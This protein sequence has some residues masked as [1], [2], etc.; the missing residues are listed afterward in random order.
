MGSRNAYASE[1]SQVINPVLIP[2]K[3]L[4]LPYLVVPIVIALMLVDFLFLN[5]RI[6]GLL[7]AQPVMVLIA[8]IL[9]GLPHIVASLF[10]YGDKNY[11]KHYK[12]TFKFVLPASLAMAILT[13][14]ILPELAGYILYTVLTLIHTI[15]QQAGLSRSGIRVSNRNYLVWRW[16]STLVACC[17]VLSLVKV[18]GLK[19]PLLVLAVL[20]LSLSSYCAIR[21]IAEA[22]GAKKAIYLVATQAML[23]T[24]F[25]CFVTGYGLLGVLIPRIVHDCTAFILYTCHD[26]THTLNSSNNAIYAKLRIKGKHVFWFLPL[27][28]VIL[29]IFLNMTGLVLITI[30]YFHYFMEKTA[31][32]RNS[33]HRSIVKFG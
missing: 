23:V 21:L 33:M 3:V 24:S 10:A 7:A 8:G 9:F 14:N 17:T 11:R 29:A 4:L 15:G 18:D 6:Q 2:V 12:N 25:T 5:Q 13:V 16:S 20:A 22:G 28:S 27:A 26:S 32:S 30:T 19:M 31:W 1:S